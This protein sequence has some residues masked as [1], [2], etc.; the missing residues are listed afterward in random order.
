MIFWN[1]PPLLSTRYSQEPNSQSFGLFAIKRVC[2]KRE[3]IFRSWLKMIPDIWE[4]DSSEIIIHLR[5]H[6]KFWEQSNVWWLFP[7]HSLVVKGFGTANTSWNTMLHFSHNY[8]SRSGWLQ[9]ERRV[10]Q[11]QKRE[12]VA[13]E[14]VCRVI[15]TMC[16]IVRCCRYTN[17]EI[18][19]KMFFKSP[20]L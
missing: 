18:T 20:P 14:N 6:H 11:F 1:W 12:Q 2:E 8:I 15:T 17:Y 10:V 13:K 7:L 4:A 3:G 5:P 16:F 19:V 9:A